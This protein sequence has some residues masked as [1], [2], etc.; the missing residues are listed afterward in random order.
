MDV[1]VR[2][3]VLG[4]GNGT[5][6][7]SCLVA[8]KTGCHR[9]QSGCGSC[10]VSHRIVYSHHFASASLKVGSCLLPPCLIPSQGMGRGFREVLVFQNL[11]AVG[12]W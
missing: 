5:G 10:P 3:D 1:A 4:F 9:V 8:Q 2:S 6:T 7:L 12:T 11:S